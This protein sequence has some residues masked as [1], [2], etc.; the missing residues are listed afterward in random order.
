MIGCFLDIEGCA[1]GMTGSILSLFPFGLYGVVFLGGMVV[2]ERIGLL[3]ILISILAWL[4]FRF[5]VNKG[6]EFT[7]GTPDPDPVPSRGPKPKPR[8][9]IGG[10]I[11]RMRRR[12]R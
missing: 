3:G 4:G 6:D 9:S 10:L 11:D 7:G 5:G 12:K 2:G 1:A 8:P